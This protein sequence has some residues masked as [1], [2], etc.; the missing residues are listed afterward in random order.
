MIRFLGILLFLGVVAQARSQ[1][2]EQPGPILDLTA[3]EINLVSDLN[4][5]SGS[6]DQ[7]FERHLIE[8]D[9]KNK[10]FRITNDKSNAVLYDVA[11]SGAYAG[12]G[13]SI[14]MKDG[15]TLFIAR[16][17]KVNMITYEEKTAT[18]SIMMHDQSIQLFGWIYIVED[19][20]K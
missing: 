17:E 3:D 7:N 10:R 11:Y 20:S 15:E 6:P 19:E 1:D 14:S 4:Q 5:M 9:L 8:I 13:K 16:D 18:F 2:D 12:Q